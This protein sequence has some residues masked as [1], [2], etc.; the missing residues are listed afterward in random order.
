[1]AKTVFTKATE[2]RPSSRKS[3]KSALIAYN[4]I[5]IKA[6]LKEVVV[7]IFDSQAKELRDEM[8]HLHATNIILQH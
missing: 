7:N 4:W 5:R 2:N 1:M 6:K 8:Q 3:F